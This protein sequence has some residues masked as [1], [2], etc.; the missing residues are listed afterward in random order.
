MTRNRIIITL[1][2]CAATIIAMVLWDAHK[3]NEHIEQKTYDL[4]VQNY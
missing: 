1:V 3:V 4:G 2:L